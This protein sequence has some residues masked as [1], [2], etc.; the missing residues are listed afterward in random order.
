MARRTWE[1]PAIVIVTVKSH[2]VD[3]SLIRLKY[4]GF[5]TVHVGLALWTA[6]GCL[7]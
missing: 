4:H 1:G 2:V 3:N 7:L 5:L 6:L